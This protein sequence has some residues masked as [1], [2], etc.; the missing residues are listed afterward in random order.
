LVAHAARVRPTALNATPDALS[1]LKALRRRWILAFGL[2]LVL[3]AMA[4]PVVWMLVP[5]SKYTATATIRMATHPKRII[6]E[7][8]ES[9]ADFS[10][11]QKTQVALIR[12]QKILSH[13]LGKL[14][15]D[16][17][18][19][20][21]ELDDS[22]GW[23]GDHL[24]V[25]FTGGSEILAISLSGDHPEDLAKIVNQVVSSYMELVVDEERKEQLNRLDQLKGLWAKYQDD[26]EDKRKALKQLAASVGGHDPVAVAL[27]QQFKNEN[28]AMARRELM[29]VQNERL[30]LQSQLT[31]KKARPAQPA[32]PVR[33]TARPP[34]YSYNSDVD[35]DP[36][37]A[38][39]RQHVDDLERAYRSVSR[40][41]AKP[42]D[43]VLVRA[44]RDLT[45]ARTQ[46]AA[47][48]AAVRDGLERRQ[49]PGER[50]QAA[51]VP[52]QDGPEHQI[53]VLQTYQD[54]LTKDIDRLT[55]ELKSANQGGL[56]LEK[57]R[58]A[59]AISAEVARKVGAEVEA[60]SVEQGAPARVQWLAEAKI[61][62]RRDE[63]KKVKAGG[64]AA[65]GA[66]AFALLGVSFWEFLA[67]RVDA[68]DELTSGLG[69]KLVG[70]L[71]ALPGRSRRAG[72]AAA[73]A[74]QRWRNVL[75]ES[76]D[77][78]RTLLLHASRLGS[79]RVVMVTSAV[80][81]EGKTS[82]SCHLATSL[83]R[84]GYRTILV[85]C[86]L[87]SPAAHR[88]FDLARGPGLCDVLR[89]E[90]RPADVIR[91][92]HALGLDL[93]PA[94]ALDALALQMIARDGLRT[95]FETLEAQ[96][97]FVIVDTPPILPVADS[98]LIVQNVD[99]VVLSVLRDVSRLPQ[100]YA[101]YERLA[102]LGA[103]MLGVVVSGV[104]S[105]HYRS[106]YYTAAQAGR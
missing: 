11:F 25:G 41:T 96:Y 4:G 102:S 43:P 89:G 52:N 20:L 53:A 15:R 12:N 79:V 10:T 66:F 77:A 30:L 54:A 73:L 6:F 31:T 80:K 24:Q 104:S 36:E 26:L 44:S 55:E 3:A 67:R 94:G 63:M 32:G 51:G 60:V 87:R 97:D 2:G 88:P 37:V 58:E 39:L 29:R 23:L 14:G 74:D 9:L 45:T 68:P 22:E 95:V 78:T 35:L 81:G 90:L 56:D 28:L 47:A 86:D 48:R 99:G 19:T 61:P 91:E 33:S 59:I 17:L 27:S 85:D 76:V 72:G 75:V 21:K 5:R 82:L 103:N 100:V 7:P 42:N 34:A 65:L 49:G 105:D 70:A 13:A 101:G 64:V 84:A 98:L 106:E 83:A 69:M 16:R 1:L 57:D 62:K 40:V 92:T 8:K 71:P 18:A 38:L 46:L 50:P 93:L